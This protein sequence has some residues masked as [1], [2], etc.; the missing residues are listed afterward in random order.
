M[1]DI[2]WSRQ[3][4][5]ELSPRLE[6]LLDSLRQDAP[7]LGI[8]VSKAPGSPMIIDCGVDDAPGSWE[9]GRRL[10]EICH[11]G[12]ANARIDTAD[13]AGWVLP[14]IIVDS[15]LPGRSTL[16]LQLSLPLS[17]I[18]D[19]IRVSGPIRAAFGVSQQVRDALP[20]GWRVAVVETEQRPSR[21]VA[22]AIA[23][24]AGCSPDDLVLIT[25]PPTGP[26]GSAQI[27]G[28]ANESVLFT[29]QE[30]LGIDA[31]CV[32][33]IVGSVPIPPSADRRGESGGI[34]AALLADDFIHYAGS[35]TISLRLPSDR[36]VSE[37]A[38]QLVFRSCQ[39]YGKL[40]GEL[41]AAA[42]G[43]FEAIPD[44]THLNKVAQITVNDE[45]TGAVARAG[46][47]DAQV[48]VQAWTDGPLPARRGD[49]HDV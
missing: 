4:L 24:R 1:R 9:A 2:A 28:R 48:L 10:V 27:A 41:L 5:V 25:V 49:N 18:S 33:Q 16:R 12:M 19:A 35:A 21:A 30:S 14:R 42:G 22:Q 7:A 8:R 15:W 11:G 38:D 20:R 23:A 29:L 34:E 6:F 36:C 32:T 44:L 45:A 17:E 39:H 46:S 47:I 43:V 37:V 31:G 3:A 13:L 26:T 40:F